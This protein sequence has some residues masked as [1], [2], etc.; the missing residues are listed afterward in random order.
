[1]GVI[2]YVNLK[3]SKVKIRLDIPL[4]AGGADTVALF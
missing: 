1:M 4:G 3:G 2:V